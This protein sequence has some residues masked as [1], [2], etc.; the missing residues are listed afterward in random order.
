MKSKTE[1]AMQALITAGWANGSTGEVEAPTGHVAIVDLTTER[2][3]MAQVL[4]DA[5]EEEGDLDA[6]RPGWYVVVEDDQGNVGVTGPVSQAEAES[7][8][9]RAEAAYAEW[10]DDGE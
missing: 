7:S 1:R 9:R 10:G 4:A 3:M 6:I 8:L 2:A 5:G